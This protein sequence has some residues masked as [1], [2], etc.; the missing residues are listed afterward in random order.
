MSG[1]RPRVCISDHHVLLSNNM[2]PETTNGPVARDAADVGARLAE[3]MR[4]EWNREQADW[5][6]QVAGDDATG[7][8]LWDSM[9]TVDSKAVARM[10]PI[11]E[12]HLGRP[13]DVGLI[14]PGGYDSIGE[15]IEALVPKM[16]DASSSSKTRTENRRLSDEREARHPGHP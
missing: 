16:M 10:S 15:V 14:R 13:L 1:V 7:T 4:A 8:D 12:K 5:D 2:L 11:F 3:D 6:A 9:P